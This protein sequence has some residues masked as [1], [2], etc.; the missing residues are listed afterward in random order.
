MDKIY[1]VAVSCRGAN[2][3]VEYDT[4]AKTVKVFLNDEKAVADA[5]KFL[6]E[7]HI[8][9]I[10]KDSLLDFVEKEIDPLA[11]VESFQTVLTRL[12]ENTDVH[13]DWSRPVEYVKAHPTLD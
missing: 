5:E 10:P 13:V 6:S 3:W 8:I 1:S 7:K 9:N 12:W 4:E 11:D 2:G